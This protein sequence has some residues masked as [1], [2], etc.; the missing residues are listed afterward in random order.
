M[1]KD[2]EEACRRGCQ[3]VKEGTV[4][5]KKGSRLDMEVV[6]GGEMRKKHVGETVR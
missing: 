1:K 3:I 4:R 6:K 2:E 5:E